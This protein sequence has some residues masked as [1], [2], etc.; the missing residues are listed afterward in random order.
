M[1]QIY[2]Y[3][4]IFIVISPSWSQSVFWEPEIPTPGGEITVFYNVLEGTLGNNT[5]PV[6][7]H[8]GYNGWEDVDD[9]AMTFEPGMGD[10]WWS[11]I[12]T[13]AEDAETIDFVFTDLLGNWDNNGGIGIDW[14]ISLNYYWVPFNPGPNHEVEIVLNDVASSGSVVWTVNSGSGFE[15]PI[16]SYWPQGTN[17]A[18]DLPWELTYVGSWV[19]T[20]LESSGTNAYHALLGPFNQGEQII[21]SI[22]YVIRWDDGS[23]DVGSN[24][25][26]IF[27]DIYFDYTAGEEDPNIIF[28]SPTEGELLEPPVL[29]RAVGDAQEVEYWIDGE[30]IGSDSTIPFETTWDPIEG[31]FGDYRIAARGRGDSGNIA[32]AF[33]NI[34]LDYEIT[35]AALP[36]GAD[37]G[38]QLSGN[39]VVITLYAPGKEYVALKGS[40]NSDYPHGELMQLADDAVW[41][42]ETTLPD[43]E[44]EYQFNIEGIKN[45]ADPWSED[46]RWVDPNGGWESGYY[47]HAYTV[48]Q[49]GAPPFVWNDAD[50]ERP[51]Q[52]EVIVYELHIGDFMSDGETHGTYLD[53]VDKIEEG[54]FNDLGI[55]AIELM[56]VNEFEGAYSWGYNPSFYMAPE[57][58]YGSPE[59]LKLL[60]D[61]A[62]QNGIAVLLD[63]VFDHLWGS[64][65]LFQL[66]QPPD[67]YEWDAHNYA[68]CPYFQDTGS[69]WEWGYK[70]DHW[71]QRTRKHLD[72]AL[73]HWIDEYHFDGY[74]FDFTAGIGWD[75]ASEWGATHYANMLNW[76]DPTLILIAEEDNPY[77][78]NTTGFD[79][80]WDYSFHH[81]MFANLSSINSGGHNFGDMA[82]VAS[83]IDA[84]SQ[85]YADH[86]AQLIYTESHDETRIVTECVEYQGY[87]EEEAYDISTLG[88]VVLMTAEGTPM[89][90][91][92]QEFGQNSNDSHL[93]PAP[94]QWENLET[95]SGQTLFENYAALIDLRKTRPAL[96]ENN[97]VVKSQ[98]SSQKSIIYWRV[99]G[100]D[101]FVIA[102]N[103]DDNDQYLNIEFPHSGEWFNVLE[104]NSITIDSN[105]C[106]NC[107]VP[108]KT[109]FLFTSDLG[110]EACLE[111]DVTE[112]GNINVLDIVTVVNHILYGAELLG[113]GLESADVNGDGA[114]NVLD[115]VTL[116]NMILN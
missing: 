53:V 17:E 42:Y 38:L 69:Q 101:A 29:L 22:K 72:D 25:Q 11:Y 113:C 18:E 44:Y 85:G 57:S 115:V 37:D 82:D 24:G 91:Q 71:Q 47:G 30:L 10:G 88:L 60:I 58:A 114:I 107:M 32:Y 66:Y 27:Y 78:M 20:P 14:H 6:Y 49:V 51:P 34:T 89:I 35:H 75:P 84:Y 59:D 61:T 36:Q 93:D 110:E 45:I 99:S 67:N 80:G 5:N 86:T 81:M 56:P 54:Y 55:N 28:L 102:A 108:A 63:I 62:H 65:P 40:W 95:E 83:H 116:A 106:G 8:I 21:Q 33:M 104:G 12:Y 64:A 48:F 79:A 52:N 74:R 43:G 77:Q 3:I 111:G 23:W 1:N 92:G 26:I 7:I 105:W 50:F 94:L 73:H 68:A 2:T 103:F 70:L 100:E 13:I 98:L 41:W 19:E 96:K 9:Y 31:L 76:E 87:D 97:L 112:D 16:E 39:H 15:T 4:L 109:A 90:Y 46:V